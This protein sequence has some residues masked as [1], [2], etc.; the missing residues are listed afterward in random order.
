MAGLL[1]YLFGQPRGLLAADEGMNS[2]GNPQPEP[3]D[4]RQGQVAGL[5]Q[6]LLNLGAGIAGG[7]NWGQGIS[8]GL[9]G[10]SQGMQQGQD[11]YRRDAIFRQQ[12]AEGERANAERARQDAFFS[13]GQPP[14]M[15]GSQPGTVTTPGST[16]YAQAGGP[17]PGSSV[18]TQLAGMI[19]DNQWSRV[20]ATYQ[21]FGSDAARD[22][23]TSYMKPQDAPDGEVGEYLSAL[24]NGIIPRGTSFQDFI[25]M[26][27]APPSS[28]EEYKLYQEQGGEASFNDWDMARRTASRSTTTVT[29]NMG[30]TGIDYGDPEPGLAWVRNPDGSV[31]LDERGA[32]IAVPY[33]GSKAYI[34]A[35]KL[36]Q[37]GAEADQQKQTVA[38]IVT[39]D[40]GR[41]LTMI[42]KSPEFTTGVG[43]NLLSG[44]PGTGARDVAALL[45]TVKANAGFEKLQ[46]MRAASPTGGALGNVTERELSLL[47]AAIGN[48]E[49]S[50]SKEQLVYNMKRVANIYSKIIDGP[51]HEPYDLAES[52]E[53]PP[54]P[55]GFTVIQ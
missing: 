2:L 11:N 10:A 48:L 27:S 21:A 55:P 34:D 54:P 19:D 24:E 51:G 1:S 36:A 9:L 52:S 12:L 50:Q 33:Q 28:I 47:Q 23:L 14:A 18:P 49:Q 32:P 45:D 15:A 31:K 13:G 26:K 5:S 37:I 8:M 53:V 42:E 25:G 46:A 35:Q 41:A 4:P 38:N 20:Q 3:Y 17:T 39:E 29:N 30:S 6:G 43:G 44:I 40:I 22:L 7:N 16:Q